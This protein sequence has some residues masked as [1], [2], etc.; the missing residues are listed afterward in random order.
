M[1]QYVANTGIDFEGMKPPLRVEA[2]APLPK[3]VPAAEI[4]QLLAD[5]HIRAITDDSAE[6]SEVE[7]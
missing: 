5:G 3:K 7:E 4:Q 1:N 2:G 6:E